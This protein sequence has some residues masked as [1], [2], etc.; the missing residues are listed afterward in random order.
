MT[1]EEIKQ[2]IANRRMEKKKQQRARHRRKIY[3]RRGVAIAVVLLVVCL[4]VKGMSMV[5]AGIKNHFSG[6]GK[7]A[8]EEV[9]QVDYDGIDLDEYLVKASKI[10]IDDI[11]IDEEDEVG[12]KLLDYVDEYPKVKI[13]L[14]DRS[15]YPDEIVSMLFN[16]METID[17]VLDYPECH[18]IDYDIEVDE[19][20][21]GQI[22]HYMQWDKRWG[23]KAYGDSIIAVGGCGPTSLAM[24]A[25]SLLKDTMYTPDY[26]AKF[27]EENGYRI[28]VGTDW[29]LMSEGAAILGLQS[30]TVNLDEV[31]LKNELESGH[32]VICSM[33]P[34]DFT[35]QGHFI[36]MT[37]YSDGLITINDPFSYSNSEKKWKFD[38]IKSQ[39]KNMW[40]FTVE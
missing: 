12:N 1:D 16:N 10:N 11:V 7:T 27:S 19:P 29:R 33:G 3:I 20:Q 18:N 4:I 40:A 36:V 9:A 32:P 31:P 26:I 23:Y 25:T 39:I 30:Q 13:I 35:R 15:S 14:A 5:V 17:F 28:S 34:G 22:I 2:R 24:V 37:D 21:D 8:T 38:D 6:D